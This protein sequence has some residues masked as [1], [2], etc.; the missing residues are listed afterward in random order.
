MC[1]FICSFVLLITHIC[2]FY[3]FFCVE[4]IHEWN[5]E[6]NWEG[7]NCEERKRK[8]RRGGGMKDGKVKSL[9]QAINCF[10]WEK[11]RSHLKNEVLLGEKQISL[12]RMQRSV[13]LK[14]RQIFSSMHR[15]H[16]MIIWPIPYLLVS[17]ISLFFYLPLSPFFCAA[18]FSFY[19]HVFIFSALLVDK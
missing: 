13:D 8:W 12:T 14:R 11:I 15:K 10:L 2:V 4:S 9:V 18:F 1:I 16:K 7:D 17:F 19:F 6:S 5:S 3:I